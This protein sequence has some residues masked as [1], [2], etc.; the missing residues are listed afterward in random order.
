MCLCLTAPV[1]ATLRLPKMFADGMVLQRNQPIRVWGWTDGGAT[2]NMTLQAT[3]KKVRA[4]GQAE[5]KADAVEH[6]RE[7]GACL[8]AVRQ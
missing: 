4:V 6:R 2:V 3:G 7:R 5:M 8:S 1:D